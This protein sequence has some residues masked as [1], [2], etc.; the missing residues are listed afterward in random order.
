MTPQSVLSLISDVENR[1]AG[2]RQGLARKILSNIHSIITPQVTKT[3][4]EQSHS[5]EEAMLRDRISRDIGFREWLKQVSVEEENNERRAYQ[6]GSV[7][8][9]PHAVYA[10]Q[11]KAFS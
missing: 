1:E 4:V 9:H 8:F 6:S 7:Q 2:K 10:R 5:L 11:T 3:S